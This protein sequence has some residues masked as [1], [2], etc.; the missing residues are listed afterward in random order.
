MFCK[1]TF[2]ACLAVSFLVLA[3]AGAGTPKK[4][5]K[6]SLVAQNGAGDGGAIGTSIPKASDDELKTL[7]SGNNSFAF[8]LMAQLRTP[9]ANLFFSPFSIRTAMAMMAVGAQGD[10]AD[11]MFVG[12]DLRLD[13]EALHRTMG[14]FLA[15]LVSGAG[16]PYELCVANSLWGQKGFGFLEPFLKTLKSHYLAEA[17]EVD[18]ASQS[19]AVRLEINAWVEKNTA[20]LIKDLVPPGG[21]SSETKMALVNAVYFKGLWSRSFDPALTQERSFH[22]ESGSVVKV[23]TM[24]QEEVVEKVAVGKGVRMLRLGYQGDRVAMDILLPDAVDG[25]EGLLADLGPERLSELA[26]RLRDRPVSI[27]IPKFSMRW[28]TVEISKSLAE[29]GM[30]DVF[31]GAPDFLGITKSNAVITAVFHQAF[32]EVTEDGTKAAAATALAATEGEAQEPARPLEFYADHPFV[33]L[34]RDLKTDSILFMG[35]LTNPIG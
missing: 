27:Q 28:G 29:L 13:S 25:L 14:A 33:F 16:K 23:P 4:Q 20:G 24:R 3:S 35:V 32:V 10:T 8:R 22:T 30:D 31:G 7:A 5:H 17:K 6:G 1:Q 21:L 19:E 2:V 34:I 12:L 9:G 26:D 11:Q 18:F 15:G